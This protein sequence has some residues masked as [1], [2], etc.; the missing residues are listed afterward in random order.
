MNGGVEEASGVVTNLR[1]SNSLPRPHIADHREK[2]LNFSKITDINK[3]ACL[4]RIQKKGLLLVD[5]GGSLA[6]DFRDF[7]G[8]KKMAASKAYSIPPQADNL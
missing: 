6:N 1:T 8:N 3:L 2:I 7:R 5:R 4:K